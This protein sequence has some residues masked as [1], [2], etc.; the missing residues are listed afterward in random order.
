MKWTIPLIY[1]YGLKIQHLSTNYRLSFSH[2]RYQEYVSVITNLSRS[3]IRTTYDDF[4]SAQNAETCK[5]YNLE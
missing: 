3:V 5:A 2:V 1:K 4:G